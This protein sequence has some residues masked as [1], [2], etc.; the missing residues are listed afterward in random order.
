MMPKDESCI[1]CGC[2]TIVRHYYPAGY[3]FDLLEDI[4]IGD[5]FIKDR[6][7]TQELIVHRC[8]VCHYVWGGNILSKAE[9]TQT[10]WVE[11]HPGV[12]IPYVNPIQYRTPGPNL[13]K[14]E[15]TTRDGQNNL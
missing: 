4:K 1:K 6:K 3:K 11:L 2:S 7:T 5:E 8:I 14:I 12:Y 10:R 13:Y 9:L 15:C